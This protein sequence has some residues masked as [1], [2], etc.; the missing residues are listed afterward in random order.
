MLAT[1]LRMLS[2]FAGGCLS[3]SVLIVF[4]RGDAEPSASSTRRAE[5]PS[6]PAVA[7]ALAE[8]QRP[9]DVEASPHDEEAA[10]A[11]SPPTPPPA[12]EH[13]ADATEPGRAIT[14][15]LAHLE[16]AYRQKLAEA[17]AST[18][19]GSA[20][21]PDAPS[22]SSALAQAP[23]GEA[24]A[25]EPPAAAAL[26]AVVGPAV[27]AAPAPVA[28]PSAYARPPAAAVAAPVA[29]A[30]NPVLPATNPA[31]AAAQP[32]VVP[33]VGVLPQN[34]H[35]GDTHNGNTYQVQQ[36][37]QYVPMYTPWA[38]G[39]GYVPPAAPTP[40]GGGQKRVPYPSTLTNP[41]NPWG[42]DFPSALWTVR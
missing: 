39:G 34:V 20:T 7:T 42:Y 11:P 22:A 16:A 27:P 8:G 9:A 14:D 23:P 2:V 37:I 36:I 1:R 40:R 32:A 38:Y 19:T 12:A 6:E 29:A 3:G 26:V 5:T 41:D 4:W 21:A 28:P 35:I 25:R 31:V 15:V 33:P 30:Q 17:P 24:A 13:S 18:A 10:P